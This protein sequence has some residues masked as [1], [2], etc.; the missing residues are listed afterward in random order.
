LLLSALVT[1]ESHAHADPKRD[2]PDYDGRGNP[3]ADNDPPAAWV[4]R[5]VLWPAY[6]VN[7]YVV[8][9]P[10]GAFVRHAEREHWANTIE[11][12]VTFGEHG[13]Q[14]IVPTALFD[15]GLL[16]SVGLYYSG[17]DLFVDGNQVRIHGATW[18]APWIDVTAVDRYTFGA[19]TVT[20]RFEFKRSEDNLFVG[21]GPD[22]TEAT[23][24]RYGLERLEG[25]IGY[26]HRIVNES[27]LD[28]EAGMHRIAFVSG[29]C[30]SDPS[31]DTRIADGELMAPPTTP[32]Y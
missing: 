32:P 20:G 31:L 19:E 14:M 22:V 26:R 16:P 10:L 29:Q 24:S 12:L 7:E 25:G 4:P 15:F 23:R 13:N 5:I 30:C 2:V 9:R 8:R 18:G 6:A 11:E 27:R 17:D 1:I 21:I 28:L 3:D